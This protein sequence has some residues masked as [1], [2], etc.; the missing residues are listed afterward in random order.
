MWDEGSDADDPGVPG[1]GGRDDAFSGQTSRGD[2][3][4][5][6]ATDSVLLTFCCLLLSTSCKEAGG[7]DGAESGQDCSRCG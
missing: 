6:R 3:C 5:F 7:F 1:P 2:G 4:G